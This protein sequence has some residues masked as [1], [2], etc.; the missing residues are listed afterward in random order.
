VPEGIAIAC[1]KQWRTFE[2]G[3]TAPSA[4]GIIV[5]LAQPLAQAG[6]S[7]HWVS[8]SPTDRLPDGETERP[9]NI[10]SRRKRPSP[11]AFETLAHC[12]LTTNKTQIHVLVARPYAGDAGRSCHE[13]LSLAFCLATKRWMNLGPI[14]LVALHPLRQEQFADL[15]NASRFTVCDFLNLILQIG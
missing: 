4:V 15:R 7:F 13:S 6:I 11:G 12:L 2:V 3:M 8:S 1:D 14:P 10:D 9:R 5:G